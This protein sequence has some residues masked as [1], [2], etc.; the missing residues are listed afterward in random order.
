MTTLT[1]VFVICYYIKMHPS[2]EG[3]PGQFFEIAPGLRYDLLNEH[4]SL[5][6][7]QSYS[8]LYDIY[9]PLVQDV[10]NPK[11]LQELFEDL[12]HIDDYGY[13]Y[14]DD[15]YT[16]KAT[17]FIGRSAPRQ[18]DPDTNTP[19]NSK[20]LAMLHLLFVELSHLESRNKTTHSEIQKYEISTREPSSAHFDDGEGVTFLSNFFTTDGQYSYKT[21]PYRLDDR[22]QEPPFDLDH[23]SREHSIDLRTPNSITQKLIDRTEHVNIKPGQ[24]FVLGGSALKASDP[25]SNEYSTIIHGVDVDP[26]HIGKTI[27]RVLN[28]SYAPRA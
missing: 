12:P 20:P 23:Y 11:K 17:K 18:I 13:T 15:F 28:I 5:E 24:L 7:A 14:Y 25:L 16:E 21:W 26:T 27:S 6:Q 9:A 10:V 1:Y 19:V 2:P 3:E 22:P 4:I 8:E